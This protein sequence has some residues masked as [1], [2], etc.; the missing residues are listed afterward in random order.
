MQVG[1]NEA[2]TALATEMLGLGLQLGL[3]LAVIRK[4]RILFWMLIGSMLLVKHGLSAR[5]V[6]EDARL[7][8]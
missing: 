8:P 6:L 4:A 1:V 7:R 5:R 2:G 3:T